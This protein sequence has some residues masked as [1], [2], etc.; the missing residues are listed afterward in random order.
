MAQA[1]VVAYGGVSVT[2]N[3][4][5]SGDVLFKIQQQLASIDSA[6]NLLTFN[7]PPTTI[8]GT[9]VSP[10]L[11]P[12]P[13]GGGAGIV[14]LVV[15]PDTDTGLISVPA[16][17]G[18]IV[19]NG[20]GTILAGP[21]QQVIGDL[22]VRGGAG[23]VAGGGKSGRVT[24]S[25]TGALLSIL[26]GNYIVNSQGDG[27]TVYL[28][29]K[30]KFNL[31]VT[32]SG[33]T[34]QVGDAGSSVPGQLRGSSFATIAGTNDTV[35]FY[36]DQN[37]TF[38]VTTGA[39]GS[40]FTMTG[41]TQHNPTTV[42]TIVLDEGATING[43]LGTL[44]VY[45][46]VGSAMTFNGTGN[47]STVFLLD[48]V[49][50]G[51]ITT[52]LHTQYYN[53]ATAAAA[54]ITAGTG[55]NDSIFALHGVNYNGAAGTSALIVASPDSTS[56]ANTISAA[57]NTT[58]YGGAAGTAMSIGGTSFFFGAGT[59]SNGGAV[60]DTATETSLSGGGSGAFFLYT[61][62]NE[63]LTI[64]TVAGAAG[65]GLNLVVAGNNTKLDATNS[66]G[67]DTVWMLG[68]ANSGGVDAVTGASTIMGATAGNET[69]QLYVDSTQAT[70]H[71]VQ[72]G[73]WQAS[74]SFNILN[75]ASLTSADNSAI[76]AFNAGGGASS[77]TLSDGT[78]I[79][80]TG[81]HPTAILKF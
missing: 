17:Y 11:I 27:Q 60:T 59:D 62:T 3:G 13:T 73:N 72:I 23:T 43:G 46:S 80:F 75:A 40:V 39:T 65:N 19:Y 79:A 10:I 5:Q 34:I 53:V 77:L 26:S 28:N 7:P 16:G 76:D 20:P 68:I 57:A 24:D 32:G 4:G 70:A 45:D 56:G 36:P 8:P 42:Q 71:T 14:N 81:D 38:I 31:N 48:S 66:L 1:T 67:H 51:N 55:A 78:T 15:I 18:Y 12:A 35:N 49:G 54:N 47:A 33:S 2:G 29:N 64:N 58:I 44:V 6:G 21:G 61:N 30:A 22:N 50:G 63:S 25:T 41:T 37:A 9:S 69:F 74:D 52:G